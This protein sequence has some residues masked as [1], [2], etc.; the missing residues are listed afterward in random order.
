MTY[1][2][3]KTIHRNDT[4]SLKWDFI[5]RNG[6]LV[7][8]DRTHE[9][10]GA[11]RTLPLWVADMD[12]PS[13]QPVLDALTARASH[14]VFGYTIPT[15]DTYNA[16]VGWMKRRHGWDISPEWIRF[17]STGI[18]PAL[19]LMIQAFTAPDEKV[20][21]QPPV[22]YPFFDAVQ[23]NDREMVFNTLVYDNGRYVMDFEDLEK[24]TADPKVTAAILCSPH[25]PVGRVWTSEELARFGEICLRHNVL[26]ISD[27]IHGDLTYSG[28][29]FTPLTMV[30]DDFAAHTAVCASPSKT[31]NLSGLQ[32]SN[33]IIPD[34]RLRA[35]FEA[36]MKRIRLFGLNTFG[37]VALEAAYNHGKEWLEQ[38]KS[39]LEG[40]LDFM[41]SYFAEHLPQIDVIRPEGT[42]MVWFDCRSLGLND[43]ALEDLMLNRARV[44]LDE[45]YI[46]GPGGSG[47]ERIN[48]ACARSLLAE[49]LGR[50]RE[51][52]DRL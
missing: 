52:V 23:N 20:L 47:F 50:I 9:K 40:N 31:F 6:K 45:G 29:K 37:V 11:E 41:M 2:F 35:R 4:L 17:T 5:Q 27:E 34:E 15:E 25:N 42:Y 49:A 19:H 10:Y 33:L 18:V 22:Y 36:A 14:G 38:V 51:A 30:R 44:F 8:W 21:I 1:N 28:V 46:F 26:I 12:F 43:T 24:K 48:I 3:D 16:V 32:T 39:Y 13:P 7:H